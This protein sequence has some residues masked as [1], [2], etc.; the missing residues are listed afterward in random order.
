[1]ASIDGNEFIWPIVVNIFRDRKCLSQR[2]H[3][4]CIKDKL[5]RAYIFQLRNEISYNIW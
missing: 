5:Q 2:E 4:T 1:M 3:I